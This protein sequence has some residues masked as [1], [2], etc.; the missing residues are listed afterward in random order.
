VEKHKN[1]VQ[2]AGTKMWD[3]QG[4]I[5]NPLFSESDDFDLVFEALE[6]LLPPI[7]KVGTSSAKSAFML[8]LASILM[9]GQPECPRSLRS[10]I[11]PA[12]SFPAVSP[13]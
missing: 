2:S 8:V 10:H 11:Y 1:L 9:L 4:R 3:L 13:P 7:Y 6:L 5:R 12:K